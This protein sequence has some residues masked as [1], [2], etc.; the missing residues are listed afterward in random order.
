MKKFLRCLI[1]LILSVLAINIVTDFNYKNV[2][3]SSNVC[4]V[5]FNFNRDIVLKYLEDKNGSIASS[6]KTYSVD[7]AYGEM[8][9][10]TRTV[11]GAVSQYYT[12]T[13]T[14]DGEEID[15]DTFRVTRDTALFAKWTPKKSTVYFHYNGVENEITNY[16]SKIDYSIESGLIVIP[17][18]IR[19]NYIF[20]GWFEN[21]NDR[22]SIVSMY[23]RPTDIGDKNLYA[24]FSPVEYYISYDTD[25]VHNNPRGYN[26]EDND[27]T[28]LSPSKEG[29]I[30]QGWYTDKNFQNHI[31]Q[32]DCSRGGNLNLY[33]KWQL[34]KYIVTFILPNGVT[35][36][37]ETEYG[38]TAELPSIQKSIFEIVRT[39]ISRENITGDTIIQIEL[40]NIWY[41][42][43]I[44]LVAIVAIIVAIIIVKKKREIVYNRLRQVYYSNVNKNK[45]KY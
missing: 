29:H 37:V 44:A 30:F 26:V 40:V 18:P 23:I 4:T 25:A 20:L 39:D 21:P 8:V 41:V 36:D 6:L 2:F 14:V 22:G 15:L 42:Y 11:N 28:L 33:V 27:I 19:P 3:A 31:T 45:R 9:E 43:F 34:E 10:E 7:V 32:I 12:Y 1:V 38:K 13:W 35:R 5:T 17:E 24:L 16:I